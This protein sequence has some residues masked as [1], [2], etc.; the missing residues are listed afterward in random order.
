MSSFEE[1]QAVTS[2]LLTQNPIFHCFGPFA[3]F[4]HTFKFILGKKENIHHYG[5]G[6]GRKNISLFFLFI[7]KEE[8]VNDLKKF[9][10]SIGATCRKSG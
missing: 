7:F 6:E 4:P 8:N 10:A 1:W 3:I 2:H 5:F 9:G